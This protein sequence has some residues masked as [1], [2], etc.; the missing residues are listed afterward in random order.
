MKKLI[1]YGASLLI[2]ASCS[3]DEDVFFGN[4]NESNTGIKFEILTAGSASRATTDDNFKTTFDNGDELGLY[5]VAHP[6]GETADLASTGNYADNYKLSYIGGQWV[7]DKEVTFPESGVELDF[8]AYYPYA[9][10]VDPKA[11]GYNASTAMY[12]LMMAK[13]A[14]ID[15]SVETVTLTFYHQLG[16]LDAQIVDGAGSALTAEGFCTSAT[17]NLG[18]YGTDEVMTCGTEVKSLPMTM[19][20]TKHFR[21]YVPAQKV[22]EDAKIVIK[23]GNETQDYSLKNENVFAGL[24]Y[25]YNITSTLVSLAD[26]PNCYM[27]KPGES[28]T[29]PVLKAFKVWQ[30]IPYINNGNLRNDGELGVT[31]IWQDHKSLITSVKL[32]ANA[33]QREQSTVTVQTGELEGNALVSVTMGGDKVWSYHIWVTNFDPEAHTVGVDNNGD[34]VDDYVFM[35]RNLGALS[36]DVN[37]PLSIGMY[38]QGSNNEPYASFTDKFPTDGT[39]LTE[40]PLYDIDNNPFTYTV[41]GIWGSDQGQSTR[42]ILTFPGLFVTSG[43]EPYSWITTD[44]NAELLYGPNYWTVEA[45]GEKGVFDPSPA[46]WMVP[47]YRNGLS[48]WA[49][50]LDGNALVGDPLSIYPKGG[51]MRFDGTFGNTTSAMLFSGTMAAPEYPLKNQ[52]VQFDGDWGQINNYSTCNG[53]NVRCVKVK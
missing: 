10:N 17:F 14:D 53:L 52:A 36:N 4:K 49:S 2:L 25:K 13:T 18:E 46:G 24:A 33:D 15:N 29:F 41:D 39:K 48:P 6:A 3:Q 23:S 5:V 44:A 47:D 34:G 51:R 20:G 11:I 31:L 8:Y 26:L 7:I 1:F 9:E 22:A 38:Y 37:N 42:R 16:L 28:V 21:A 50:Y 12:D 27:V 35:D 43:G 32:N 45:T 30:D 40:I 19:V